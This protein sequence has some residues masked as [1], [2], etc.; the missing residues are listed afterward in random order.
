MKRVFY[1]AKDGISKSV[2]AKVKKMDKRDQFTFSS[3]D[4]KKAKTI[5]TGN[6]SFLRRD[7]YVVFLE[8]KRV[9]VK[10]NAVLRLFWLVGGP[11]K[12]LGFFFFVPGFIVN[13]IFRLCSL[14]VRG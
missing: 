5:F 11:F 1:D 14:F 13:P 2:I 3:L 8:G 4:G 6:Y 12:A 9:W 7:K 10:G